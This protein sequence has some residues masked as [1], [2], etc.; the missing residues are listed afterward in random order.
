MYSNGKIYPN[1]ILLKISDSYMMSTTSS[2]FSQSECTWYVHLKDGWLRLLIIKWIIVQ[3]IYKWETMARIFFIGM[4]LNCNKCSLSYTLKF[5][6]KISW[7]ITIHTYVIHI[8]I[9]WRYNK[10]VIF[11][12]DSTNATLIFKWNLSNIK[13]NT[14]NK[15]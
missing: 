13:M 2:A 3:E 8:G 11:V 14:G 7:P 12:T 4:L 10:K 6:M 9:I 15:K 5:L 1:E